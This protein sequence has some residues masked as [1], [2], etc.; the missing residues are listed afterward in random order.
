MEFESDLGVGLDCF[1]VILL[2]QFHSRFPPCP[3]MLLS[4]SFSSYL[5]LATHA[6]E[7]RFEVVRVRAYLPSFSNSNSPYLV[8]SPHIRA[9]WENIPPLILDR[10]QF[11]F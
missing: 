2:N 9:R 11:M 6:V 4:S 8:S 3:H 1:D 10:F 5:T 7:S